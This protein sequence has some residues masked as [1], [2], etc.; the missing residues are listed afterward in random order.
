V[1]L[2]SKY[3]FATAEFNKHIDGFCNFTARI[4]YTWKEFAI[5]SYFLLLGLVLIPGE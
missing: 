3:I 2:G 5:A 4:N 1:F